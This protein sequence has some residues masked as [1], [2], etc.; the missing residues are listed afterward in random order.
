[1]E[2]GFSATE[3][4]SRW[5]PNEIWA[6]IAYFLP[7]MPD[8]PRWQPWIMYRT[9]NKTFKKAVEDYYIVHWLKST[10][11]SIQCT[12]YMRFD[13]YCHHHREDYAFTSFV[14]TENRIAVLQAEKTTLNSDPVFQVCSSTCRITGI[15]SCCYI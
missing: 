12:E 1:M 15:I 13:N 4:R 8:Q 7:R 10:S 11:I 6:L 5:F 3:P 9:L 2:E 14:D